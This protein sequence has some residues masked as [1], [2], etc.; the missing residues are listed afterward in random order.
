MN[1]TKKLEQAL[2]IICIWAKAA[3]VRGDINEMIKT[4]N[5]INK[6]A[7]DALGKDK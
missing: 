2:K 5:D 6:M 3:A 7:L 4:L 1:P